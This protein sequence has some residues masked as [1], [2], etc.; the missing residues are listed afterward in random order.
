MNTSHSLKIF[1]NRA[2]RFEICRT[3]GFFQY[4]MNWQLSKLY[5][6]GELGGL[7][8]PLVPLNRILATMLAGKFPN[9]LEECGLIFFQNQ[10]LDI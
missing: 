9:D 8:L 1:F 5:L 6:S 7:T 3:I 10:L 4:V 2:S